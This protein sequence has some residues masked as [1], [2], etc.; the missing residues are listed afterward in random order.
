M[1]VFISHRKSD[2]DL[3][4]G[5][6]NYLESKSV[7]AYLDELD[8]NLQNSSNITA[9][10]LTRLSQCSHLLAIVTQNT[11]GSWWVPWEIGVATKSDTR[12]ASITRQLDRNTLP[13]YL[14]LW[15][16]LGYTVP[17]LDKFIELYKADSRVLLERRD[18]LKAGAAQI[19]TADDFHRAMM[20]ATGQL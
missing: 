11:N 6:F 20:R 7:Q 10:I 14:K 19:R 15:P 8:E 18:M 17:D 16:L 1:P 12:I 13:A 2:A 4:R 9:V 5:V 3:A